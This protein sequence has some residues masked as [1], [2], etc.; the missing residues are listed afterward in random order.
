M[1]QQSL[2]LLAL[3]LVAAG[4]VTKDRFYGVT[5]QLCGA[6]AN[7]YGVSRSDGVLN[8]VVPVDVVGTAI[9]EAGAPVAKD[10]LIESDAT[11]RAITRA[12]G[13]ILGRALQAA[14]GAGSRIE[15]LLIQN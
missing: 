13:V 12:A 10:A 5:H 15:V 8:D 6:G 4:A 7:A 14:S 11:G 9:V 1:S 2:S 3:S